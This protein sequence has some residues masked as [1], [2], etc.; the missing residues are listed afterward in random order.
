MARLPIPGRDGDH[1]GAVLNDVLR[2]GHHEDGSL[3]G[4][5][6]I[7]NV[8]DFGAKGDGVTD[9]TAAIQATIDHALQHKLANVYM[10]DG[11]YLTNGPI[12]LGYGQTFTTVNLIG[13]DSMFGGDQ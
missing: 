13:A 4:I 1:W 12:H 10:P 6:T 11:L 7:A 3:R 8:K 9:D 2:V 5:S